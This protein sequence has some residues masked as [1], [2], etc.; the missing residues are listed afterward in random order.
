MHTVKYGGD[1]STLGQCIGD[2]THIGIAIYRSTAR[3]SRTVFLQSI[4]M[5]KL[6]HLT[7]PIF[8]FETA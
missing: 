1:P 8:T 6:L 4:I 7:S 2:D 3:L 5:Q